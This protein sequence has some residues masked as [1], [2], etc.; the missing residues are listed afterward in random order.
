[1]EGGLDYLKSVVVDDSLGL[2]AELER[3]MEPAV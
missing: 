2:A 3:R 1:M